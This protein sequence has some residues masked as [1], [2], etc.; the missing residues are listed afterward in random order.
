[1]SG[2]AWRA[3]PGVRPSSYRSAIR[4]RISVSLTATCSSNVQE[5]GIHHHL[6]NS[7]PLKHAP[8]TFPEHSLC[9]I[10]SSMCSGG[11]ED[12]PAP[13]RHQGHPDHPLPGSRHVIDERGAVPEPRLTA[14]RG[15]RRQLTALS[16]VLDNACPRAHFSYSPVRWFHVRSS[17]GNDARDPDYP[18]VSACPRRP[19]GWSTRTPA[20]SP[21][22]WP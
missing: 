22:A 18:I 19:Q 6:E 9:Y 15:N 20:C 3:L 5:L 13:A 10:R 7:T 12:H 14:A 11:E 8:L 17:G 16:E 21:T 2:E 1:M 4:I